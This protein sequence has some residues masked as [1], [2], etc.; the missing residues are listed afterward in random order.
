[1]TVPHQY[2]TP[3]VWFFQLK[4]TDLHK[5]IDCNCSEPASLGF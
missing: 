3:K 5:K 4:V 1:M 2:N